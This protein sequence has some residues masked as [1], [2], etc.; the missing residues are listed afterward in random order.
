L[1]DNTVVETCADNIL[2]KTGV[3]YKDQAQRDNTLTYQVPTKDEADFVMDIPALKIRSSVPE[4]VLTTTFEWYNTN[5]KSADG[6]VTG[7]WEERRTNID[8]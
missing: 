6:T 7:R 4:C 5:W 1:I 2:S 3:T 8:S